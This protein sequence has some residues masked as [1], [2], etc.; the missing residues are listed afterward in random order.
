[1]IPETKKLTIYIGESDRWHHASLWSAIFD[2]IRGEGC[3]GATVLRG[4]AGF[5]ASSRV[6]TATIL[7][8]SIDMPIIIYV[9]DRIDRLERVLPKLKAMVGS[10]L[11]T[12][13]DV[14][15]LKYTPPLRR[16]LPELTVADIM[17][18]KVETVTR[19]TPVSRV[20]E[21]LIDKDYTALPVVDDERHVLG[22]IGDT[23]LMETGEISMTL[24]IPRAAGGSIAEQMLAKL[25]QSRRKVG[26]VMKAPAVTIE[27]TAVLADAA[28]RMV[29]RGLKR[30]PVVDSEGRLVGVLGRLDVLKTMASVHLPKK[31]AQHHA[32][33]LGEVPHR[34]ADVMERNVPT[35]A[36]DMG[37]DEV[38]DLTVGSA[39]S[40]VVVVDSDRRPLGIVTDS[41]LVQR[42]DPEVRISV[43]EAFR[44]RIP[45][46][47]IGGEARRHLAKIRGSRAADVMSAPAVTLG[48]DTPFAEALA[49][50][51]ER[52]IKRFPVVD[53][54]GR[55][56]GIVGRMELLAGF[57]RTVDE[58]SPY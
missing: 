26:D 22:T 56:V 52:H 53:R 20:I 58:G 8:V 14:G 2:Y 3:A 44:S 39:V 43:A 42:L 46:E 45:I 33:P 16:G 27:V 34:I 6:R 29:E 17:T 54:E 13:E 31:R 38:I 7:D 23:D 9:I 1:M 19:E 48:E 41:D 25:R 11:M 57:L 4:H 40:R 28:H 35:A 55:L 12:I 32:P 24:S 49:V 18:T 51:A 21:I 10:G 47:S 37:L 15:V 5:G 36:P 50:S 30:L